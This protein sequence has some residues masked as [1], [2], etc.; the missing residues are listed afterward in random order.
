MA[1]YTPNVWADGDPTKPLSA[2]RLTTMETGIDRASIPTKQTAFPGSPFDGQIEIL[3]AD[4]TNGVY[5]LFRY[6]SAGG[7][8]KWEFIGGAPLL[9]EVATSEA[10][11]STTYID[12]A[13][14]GPQVTIPAAGDYDIHMGSVITSGAGGT[15]I[16]TTVKL[17][18]AAAADTEAARVGGGATQNGSRRMR[19]NGLAAS[20]V[21]KM[22]YRTDTGGDSVG[23]ERRYL[24]VL[25]IRCS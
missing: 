11:D 24:A 7:T 1:D 2:A 13:T 15:Q 14:T 16:Y 12:L 23:V 22:M 18:A 20:A 19:R 25:P 10:F 8:H 5:W 17:G 6:R 9:A 4:A 21:L 3:E